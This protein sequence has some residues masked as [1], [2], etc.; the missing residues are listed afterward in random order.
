[1]SE[2]GTQDLWTKRDKGNITQTVIF[3]FLVF[4]ITFERKHVKL[5]RITES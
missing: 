5:Y 1:M 3:L 2:K 4:L